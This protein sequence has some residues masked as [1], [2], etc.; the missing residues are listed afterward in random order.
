MSAPSSL[1]TATKNHERFPRAYPF[2]TASIGNGPV[3]ARPTNAGGSVSSDLGSVDYKRVSEQRDLGTRPWLDEPMWRTYVRRRLSALTQSDHVDG[4]P[5]LETLNRA[6]S[7]V[8]SCLPTETPT[9][10]VNPGE[11]RSVDFVWHRGS[12]HIELEVSDD[13]PFVFAKNL[14][15]A[16]IISGDLH[17]TYEVF[18]DLL[19][20]ISAS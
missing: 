4:Y 9:P 11:E 16:E 19:R 5:V 14:Q 3:S 13:P 1:A 7:L 20:E 6:W 17:S 18:R 8:L 10:S 2:D 15:N 12:W